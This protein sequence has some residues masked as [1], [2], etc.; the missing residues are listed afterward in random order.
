MKRPNRLSSLFIAFYSKASQ[1][2]IG[3][4]YVNSEYRNLKQLRHLQVNNITR[5]NPPPPHLV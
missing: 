3:L 4:Y 1:T 2:N 5:C